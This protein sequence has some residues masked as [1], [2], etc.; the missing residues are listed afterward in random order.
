MPSAK[1]KPKHTPAKRTPKH[2]T[3]DSNEINLSIKPGTKTTFTIEAGKEHAGEIPVR[4]HVEQSQG[5]EEGVSAGTQAKAKKEAWRL[6]GRFRGWSKKLRE[7]PI[8]QKHDLATWLF[9]GSLAVYLLTRLIGLTKFPIYFFVDE[10]LQTQFA[11]DLVTNGYRGFN[12]VLFPP[13]FQ[14]GTYF[15]LGMAVYMQLLPYLIFGKL[16]FVTRATSV[17]VTLIAA[18]SAGLILRDGLKIK[19]WWAGVLFFSITPTWFLHSRT[20]WEMGE[21]VGFYSGALCAYMF[22]RIKSPK[23]LYLAIFLGALG[24]YTYSPGQVLVPFTAFALAIFDWRYHW[25]NRRTILPGL[26]LLFIMTIPYLRFRALDPD[27]AM[28]HLHNLGSFLFSDM[29]LWEKI[30]KYFSNY[31][32]GLGAW[33]WY[34]PT[35]NTLQRH[36]M[37][38]YGH[39]MI[40]T[41]PFA[42]LGLVETTRRLREP[43]YRIILTAWL[44]APVATAF[45]EVGI[46]RVLTYTFA[47]ALLTAIGLAL[48][49]EW[50]EDPTK[51]LKT[52]MSA[53]S[54]SRLKIVSAVGILVIGALAAFFAEHT[55][56]R[57][58]AILISLLLAL[59]ISGLAGEI[60]RRMKKT[61]LVKGLK[62]WRVSQYT[63][64]WTVFLILSSVNIFMLSDALRNGPTWYKDYGMGGLQYG[65]FQ[66]FDSIKEYIKEH[67]D[68]RILFSPNWANGTDVVA[69][70]FLG[71]PL[72]VQLHSIQ[73]Y[74]E[75]KMQIGDDTLFIMTKDEYE[76]ALTSDKLADIRVEKTISY[77]DG[78]PGFYFVRLRYSDKADKE[79][80]QEEALRQVIQESV[81][82][83]DGED[84]LVRHTYLEANDQAEGLQMAF[85]GD[86]YT[87]A[88]TYEANPFMMEFTFPTPRTIHG[89]SIIIG[90]AKVSITLTGYA[91]LGADPVTYTFEGQGAMEQPE[92]S[93]E[94]PEPMTAQILHVEQ[95]D[96]NAPM[97]T[98][99]HVWELTFR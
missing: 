46:T 20:A 90:A 9:W 27:N 65:A 30:Q 49:L 36:I 94:F 40:A 43:A 92:L 87:Y 69:R 22:Y 31:F 15:T 54:P 28:A 74:V 76:F 72:P 24:F 6:S 97:P 85:D 38:G 93:F 59:Q 16:P 10:A 77:P 37:K 88:K 73:G 71:D 53:P 44:A 32:L 63:A 5:E 82:K 8:F 26:V 45:V 95:L 89:F 17:L 33:Y 62:H 18:S 68:T 7:N 81:I 13:A 80:A 25:E 56:D 41:L 50:V 35:E 19:H 98:K 48:V 75:N 57:V 61:N 2:L 83:I 52:T 58:A 60:A 11:A 29:S 67:P 1:R 4:I 34:I 91:S 12:N 96:V 86:P 23:Y 66:V 84:V 55:I 21:F 99:N 14:N 79:F 3:S 70:Y 78:T 47:T 39:I 42:L 64:A 51:R